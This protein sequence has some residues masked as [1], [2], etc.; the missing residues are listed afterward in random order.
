MPRGELE[1]SAAVL[2]RT[3]F[4]LIELDDEPG[5][6]P[7]IPGDRRMAAARLANDRVAVTLFVQKRE[8]RL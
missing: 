3:L 2:G 6:R 1:A 7:V 5:R 8:P 4:L